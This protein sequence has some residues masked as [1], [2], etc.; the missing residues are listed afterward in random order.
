LSTDRAPL[1]EIPWHTLQ[2]LVGAGATGELIIASDAIEIHVYLLD[3]RLAWATSS[4]ARNEF[5]RRLVEIHGIASDVL[6][7]V[8]EECRRTRGRLGET[9][10]T[11]GVAT[12]EQI[13]DALRGQIEEALAAAVSHPGARCLFLPRRLEYAMELT[14]ALS[15]LA[16]EEDAAAAVRT[17]DTAEK[18]VTTV[19][20]G[21]P[22]ALWVEVIEEGEVVAR[23]LR[24]TIRPTA[25][26]EQLQRLVIDHEIDALTLRSTAH[27]AVLGQCLPGLPAAVWCA[28]GGGAKLGVT[29]AVLASAVG[30]RAVVPAPEPADEP[31]H[32]IVDPSARLGPSVFAG[33]TRT[34]DEL[35]AGFALGDS[36][37]PTGVWR[38]GLSLE[39]HAAWARRL[40][41]AL[42]TPIRDAFSRA[43]GS[44]L[45]DH[46]ALR[47][48]VGT[49]AYYGTRIPNSSIAVWL[50][51]RTW[52]SQGLGWAL[53]QTVA[54]QVGGEE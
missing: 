13:R 7:D 35:V 49:T 10:I 25:A 30:A 40:A 36:G 28:V 8:I 54:R 46:V 21:V 2:H 24:G 19:L 17:S 3:G 32:E 26:V 27:G 43:V 12:A 38:G 22:D 31:W 53:L 6:R 51:L 18:V 16:I 20:D 39:D 1:A 47:A 11:W 29:S 14:F 37:G 34:R 23:A 48:V 52:A 33:A 44:L 9:L 4:T 45:Y 15:E 42:A 41:P 5:L 50:V